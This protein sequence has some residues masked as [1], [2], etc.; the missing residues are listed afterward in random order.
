MYHFGFYCNLCCFIRGYLCS[1]FGR[2][3]GASL[4]GAVPTWRDLR[5]SLLCLLGPPFKS[6]QIFLKTWQS[7][8]K[9]QED[10]DTSGCR[11]LCFPLLLCLQRGPIPM[12][13]HE[14]V[15]SRFLGHLAGCGIDLFECCP[16]FQPHR[17]HYR[18]PCKADHEA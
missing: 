14:F 2:Y 3:Q 9:A 6:V 13:P 7:T 11:V 10:R 12:H 1:G 15:G 16:A 8:H 4:S 18:G 5:P 17:N